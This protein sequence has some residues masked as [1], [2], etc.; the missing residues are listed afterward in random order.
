LLSE[1]AV[2]AIADAA[3]RLKEAE[4]RILLEL[5]RRQLATG[6]AVKAS[7][8]DLANA[9][10]IAR[11]ETIPAIASLTGRCL[12]TRRRGGPKSDSV[13]QVN[14]T[15]TTKISGPLRGPPPTE[16]TAVARAA[17]ASRID[18]ASLHLIARVFSS[19]G[20][21]G[22]GSNSHA[23][24]TT[25]A[26]HDSSQANAAAVRRGPLTENVGH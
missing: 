22:A 6:A 25:P 26:P 24:A 23:S 18:A 9:C 12:I 10:K 3:P 20:K 14:I 16:N 13:Y 8:S 7:N 19:K 5:T 1:V 15:E 17:A 4:L 21:N 2:E 11:S